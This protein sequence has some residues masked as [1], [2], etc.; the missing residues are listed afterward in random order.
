MKDKLSEKVKELVRIQR[1]SELVKMQNSITAE[2]GRRLFPIQYPIV[3]SRKIAVQEACTRFAQALIWAAPKALEGFPKGAGK[4][5]PQ[6]LVAEFDT[7][8]K[9]LK[10]FLRRNKQLDLEPLRQKLN[11]FK[12]P[13][14]TVPAAKVNP[15]LLFPGDGLVVYKDSSYPVTTDQERI[16]RSCWTRWQKAGGTR[17]KILSREVCGPDTDKTIGRI[18]KDHAFLKKLKVFTKATSPRGA[19]YFNP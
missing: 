16:L 7:F 17:I 3:D 13:A 15:G 9:E 4:D 2:G 8:Q 14:P 5:L 11:G 12:L 19:F 1:Q 10:A 18:F 6:I